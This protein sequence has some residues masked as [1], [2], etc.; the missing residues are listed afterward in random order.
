MRIPLPLLRDS[1]GKI[2]A[3]IEVTRDITERKKAE[4]ELSER[5]RQAALSAEVGAALIENK[6]MRS[7]LQPCA[8]SVVKHLD[9]AFARIWT[10]NE[11]DNILELQASAGMYTHI[12]GPHGRVPVGKFKIGLIA[13]EKK[14]HLTNTV[15]DDPRISDPA[16]AKREGMV[17]FAGHPLIVA[18]KLVGVMAMFSKKPLNET[19]LTALATISDE[20]ALGIERKKVEEA[21]KK[22]TKHLK[23]IIDTVP[24]CIKLVA[25]DGTF[26]EMN[27]AGLTMIEADSLARLEGKSI[28]SL[29][30]PEYREVFR[31]LMEKTYKG[32][33]GTLEF[34]II[35]LKGTHR[36]MSMHS[37]PFRD[38]KGEIVAL[39]GITDDITEN[40]KLREQLFQAQKMEAVGQLAAGI[41]H[42]F[43]NIL[44]AIVGYGHILRMRT[45]SD[46]PMMVNIEHI[47][48][49]ADK[50]A[51]LT[52]DLLA[53]SRKKIINVRPADLNEI[54][55]KVKKFLQRIIGEDIEVRTKLSEEI[56]TANVDSA[57][58]EQAL[59]N[60]A[61]NAKDAMPGGGL[62]SI[63][64]AF[65]MMNDEF[66]KA[67]GFGKP[68][69][70]ALISVTDT[71]VGMDKTTSDKIFEPFFTTK[72]VGKGTGLG[73]A[74][75]YGTVKQHNGYITVYSE[76]G[77]GTTFRI[78]IPLVVLSDN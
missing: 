57:Q 53:F 69:K 12:D 36:W 61:T 78:Y 35:G 47:L 28:Y 14:P 63:E 60:L 55:R 77:K 44:T 29:L 34:E 6:D 1:E 74:M 27:P 52:Q 9:A 38:A 7:L 25:A 65:S 72:E 73:L 37:V 51:S 54:I 11:K 23:I 49:S 42:D 58:I 50:A 48:E 56:L 8:E 32:E 75:V 17:A 19:T 16:W 71:G 33:E 15:I 24:H 20:I 13:Q 64:T 3:G 26:L 40:R 66:K 31:E 2:I 62:L 68:G 10:L 67:H 76:P 5:E 45:A 70:Y 18:D 30:A 22:S 59:I 4:D 43:N 41:A 39:L 21:L 46:D